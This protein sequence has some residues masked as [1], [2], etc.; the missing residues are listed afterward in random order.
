MVMGDSAFIICPGWG[1]GSP[2]GA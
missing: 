2:T 1:R